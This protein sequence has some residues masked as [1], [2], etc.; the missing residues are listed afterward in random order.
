LV[1]IDL[2]VLVKGNFKLTPNGR[3]TKVRT[4]HHTISSHGLR[5]GELKNEQKRFWNTSAGWRCRIK[6]FLA[7]YGWVKGFNVVYQQFISMH[8]RVRSVVTS[9][10]S[11]RFSCQHTE[12][13]SHTLNTGPASTALYVFN[14]VNANQGKQQVP[15][16]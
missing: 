12:V 6:L 14:L 4:L 3:T 1:E 2:I 10:D 11:S 9:P 5:P 7:E 15:F 16:W 13:P 8:D